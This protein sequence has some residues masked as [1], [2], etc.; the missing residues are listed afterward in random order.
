[1]EGTGASMN[2]FR[3]WCDDSFVYLLPVA[4]SGQVVR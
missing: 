4:I 1:M 2:S 3:M